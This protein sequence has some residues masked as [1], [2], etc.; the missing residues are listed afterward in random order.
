M[1]A[2]YINQSKQL[3]ELITIVNESID[4]N[5]VLETTLEKTT[6]LFKADYGGIYTL[7]KNK[8]TLKTHSKANPDIV[9]EVSELEPRES[10]GKIRTVNEKLSEKPNLIPE[11]AK[12][13]GIQSVILIPIKFRDRI[14]G[15]LALANKKYKAFN[16]DDKKI[17]EMISTPIGLAI[18]NANLYQK[19][20][21]ID[22][23]TFALMNSIHAAVL[24]IQDNTILWCN[25]M[26]LEIFGYSPGELTGK[27]TKILVK[28]ARTYETLMKNVD[29]AMETKGRFCFEFNAVRKNRR[30]FKAECCVS[31]LRQEGSEPYIIVAV[32][33]DISDKEGLRAH[34]RE[35]ESTLKKA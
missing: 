5:E 35:L 28:D 31:M 24:T 26:S 27:S 18:E 25:P 19:I 8:L 9:K 10:A 16:E 23:Y 34:V 21:G 6:D 30:G 3:Y 29:Y 1:V 7:Q 14:L 22:Q 17:A 15:L 20:K 4:V 2:P 12:K 32:I 11:R 13:L 33:R